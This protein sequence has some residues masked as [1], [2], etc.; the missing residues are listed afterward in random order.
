MGVNCRSN[1]APSVDLSANED[2]QKRN[3]LRSRGHC[4][5]HT[6]K[7]SRDESS[8]A[9][10]RT[11]S[12]GNPYRAARMRFNESRALSLIESSTVPVSY[13]YLNLSQQISAPLY[14][15][16]LA[17]Y[18]APLVPVCLI[19]SGTKD[20]RHSIEG[21]TNA[22]HARLLAGRQLRDCSSGCLLLQEN[23]CPY[24]RAHPG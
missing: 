6:A 10:E 19:S 4:W 9:A 3:V 11:L 7:T 12:F 16:F 13:A 15:S 17:P 20:A 23:P 8:V 5:A 18:P 14:A 2:V 22:H 1:E 21:S 24:I